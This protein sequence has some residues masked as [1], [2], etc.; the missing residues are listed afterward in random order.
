MISDGDNFLT[1]E[2]EWNT[3]RIQLFPDF[4]P[5]CTVQSI[6]HIYVHTNINY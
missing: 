1:A 2:R 5:L 6:M 3:K 4:T